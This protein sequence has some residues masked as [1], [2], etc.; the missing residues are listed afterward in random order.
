MNR[1]GFLWRY[2]VDIYLTQLLPSYAFV[3]FSAL[4]VLLFFFLIENF[5]VIFGFLGFIVPQFVLLDKIQL[6]TLPHETQA[7]GLVYGVLCTLFTM[8]Y[9]FVSPRYRSVMFVMLC[10]LLMA[11]CVCVS[12]FR[13]RKI[14]RYFSI[15][16]VN[17]NNNVM[18]FRQDI[19]VSDAILQSIPSE[20]RLD[21]SVYGQLENICA[22][23]S[24]YKSNDAIHCEVLYDMY[25][26]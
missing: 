11:L 9:V 2:M 19:N 21:E 22:S 10:V 14:T 13:P 8:H 16:I 18:M 1:N 5:G 12:V 17:N 6:V 26:K 20:G 4:A 3:G 24:V 7:Q 25:I 15:G 23:C